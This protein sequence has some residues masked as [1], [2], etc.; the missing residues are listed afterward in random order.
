M[1]VRALSL[2]LKEAEKSKERHKIGAVIFKGSK[3]ISSGHNSLRGCSKIPEKYKR[4]PHSL[5]AEQCAILNTTPEKCKR[6]SIIVVRINRKGNLLLAKPCK[7][8]MASLDYVGIKHIYYSNNK[9][10]IVKDD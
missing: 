2:A 7:Y 8:C 6:A 4:F 5:H 1:N 10:E 9:G 3:I